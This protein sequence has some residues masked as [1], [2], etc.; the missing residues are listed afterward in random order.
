[1]RY[2]EDILK[3]KNEPLGALARRVAVAVKLDVPPRYPD[4]RRRQCQAALL[5]E[6]QATQEEIMSCICEPVVIDDADVVEHD[7]ACPRCWDHVKTSDDIATIR[8]CIMLWNANGGKDSTF[9]KM[10]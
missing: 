1:M 2:I 3:T 7:G 6:R 10:A 5:R 9:A 4:R 8:R